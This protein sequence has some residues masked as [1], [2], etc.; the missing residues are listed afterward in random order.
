MAAEESNV[1]YVGLLF[2]YGSL[3]RGQRHHGHLRGADLEG[4]ASVL[5][6][7]LHDLGPFP[8]AVVDP[9]GNAVVHG[10]IYA[11]TAEQLDAID[12]FEGVPRLYERQL[13]PLR[14]GRE[15]WVYVGRA[16]QVRYSPTIA[17]GCWMESNRHQPTARKRKGQSQH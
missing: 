17:S 16:R 11:I 3:K 2:V 8:M 1:D 6:L 9:T 5:G 10:E 4:T 7:S 12:R 13:H 14:D 15:V